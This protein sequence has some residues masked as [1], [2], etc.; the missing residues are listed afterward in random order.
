MYWLWPLLAGLSTTGLEIS[1]RTTSGFQ[2]WWLVAGA[3]VQ[4]AFWQTFRGAPSLL[5]AG[6]IIAAVHLVT[7]VGV[8]HFWLDEPVVR[9]NLVVAVGLLGALVIGWVWR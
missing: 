1:Y 6:G 9:G 2:W 4:V 7:R 8:S 3:A 5:M